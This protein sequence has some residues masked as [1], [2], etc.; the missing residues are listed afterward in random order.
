MDHFNYLNGELYCEDVPLRQIAEKVGTPA[1]VYS[2][3]TFL[4][5]YKRIARAFAEVK[6]LICYSIKSCSNLHLIKLLAEQ[7]AGMDV[8]SGGELYRALKA[9]VDPAKIVYAG[10][11]KTD[12]EINE[13]LDAGI[14]LFNIESESELA[15]L[16]AIAEKRGKKTRAALRIN[17]DVDPQTHRHT[18]TGKREAKFGVDLERARRVFS[19]LG[20]SPSVQLCAVHLHIGSPVNTT[21]PYVEAVTKALALI[22]ELRKDGFKIDTIDVGGGFGAYY[23]GN[24]ALP[25]AA[26]AEALLP[27]LR[28]RNL[29][30]ILEPG[31]SISANGG[32]LL[33][34]TVHVKQGGGDKQFLIVDASMS[35][36]IRPPLYDAYHFIW[37]VAPGEQFIPLSRLREQPMPGLIEMDV[38]G[39]VCES[40]DYLAKGRKLPPMKRGDFIAVFTAGAYGF[41]MASHY[42]SRPN[43]PEILVHGKEFKVIRQRESYADLIAAEK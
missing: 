39:P 31:R 10:V 14:G 8:V 29:K 19:E 30:V 7:G 3:G 23:E 2:A 34:Q 12:Q 22:D 41:C 25:A 17:P 28:G 20:R 40:T 21:A 33:A 26:Y 11:G 16:I 32:L 6:P 9:G 13:S 4:E 38:V 24:E 1:Y 27:L 36:L 15:N 18:S 37:P 42:N 5:H 35:E 43:P